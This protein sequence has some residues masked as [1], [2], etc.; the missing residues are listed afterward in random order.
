MSFLFEVS[1]HAIQLLFILPIRAIV[2]VDTV[3]ITSFTARCSQ[4]LMDDF[5]MRQGRV[6]APGI[7]EF[8]PMTKILLSEKSFL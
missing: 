5:F 4:R 3:F 7:P 2:I 1:T 6:I 8:S